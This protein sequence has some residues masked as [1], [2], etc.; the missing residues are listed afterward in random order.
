VLVELAG[1]LQEERIGRP[2]RAA[3][4]TRVL[5][6]DVLPFQSGQDSP[7]FDG[8]KRGLRW[9]AAAGRGFYT[10]LRQRLPF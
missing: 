10:S 9:A 5:V 7:G 8:G 6:I 1:A 4:I 2:S 3:A